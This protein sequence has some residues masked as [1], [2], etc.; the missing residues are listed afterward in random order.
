MKKE[1]NNN[2][3]N[4]NWAKHGYIQVYTGNGKGKTT[5][6]LGL[7]MRALGR[8]WKVLIIMFTKG[9][10]DYGE[11]NS[12]RNLSKEISDNLT[13]I[14][15]GMDRIVYEGNKSIEDAAEISRGWEIAKKAIK[16]DEYNLIILD[17]A[18]IAIDLGFIDIN[19]VVDVLKSKPQEMEIVLTGRNAK[20]EIIN[21]AHLV[22]EIKPVKHY[23][24]TGVVARKGIE[25]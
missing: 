22:S 16:N 7:A 17:E 5:A 6:S 19:E 9:G 4:P 3:I 21:I 15:A 18:N 25:Y 12:F 13:I 20:K 14:Q 11:L 10:N 8:S 24:D 1:L 2:L 23:W